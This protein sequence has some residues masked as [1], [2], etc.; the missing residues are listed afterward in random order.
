MN[1]PLNGRL[2]LLKLRVLLTVS[3]VSVVILCVALIGLLLT[4]VH[5]VRGHYYVV[6]RIRT[7]YTQ[8]MYVLTYKITANSTISHNARS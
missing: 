3:G 2:S 1:L 5:V 6:Y 8:I 4:L 7:K